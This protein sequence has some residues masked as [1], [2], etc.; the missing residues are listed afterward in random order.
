MSKREQVEATL[1]H[2]P[3]DRV[4]LFEQLSYNPGVIA[5]WTGKKINGLIIYP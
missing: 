1:N 4:A 3:L 2:E 5:D